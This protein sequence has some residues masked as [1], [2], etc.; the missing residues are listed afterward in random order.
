MA[1]DA[2]GV[3]P[4]TAAACFLEKVAELSQCRGSTQAES[5]ELGELRRQS[6]VSLKVL[7]V[8][9]IECLLSYR[10]VPAVRM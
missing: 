7:R 2:N 4:V 8:L 3:R 1:D 6:W 5:E 10:V 9:K